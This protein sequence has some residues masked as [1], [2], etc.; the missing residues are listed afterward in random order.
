MHISQVKQEKKTIKNIYFTIF[1]RK[2][3]TIVMDFHNVCFINKL[4]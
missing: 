4:A 3:S 1:V 2:Y